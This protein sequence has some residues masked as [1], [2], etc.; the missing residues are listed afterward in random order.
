[1]CAATDSK[2]TNFHK[3]FMSTYYVP[4]T[5]LGT[6]DTVINKTF[7]VPDHMCSHSSEIH[8]SMLFSNNSMFLKIHSIMFFPKTDA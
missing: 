1:M 6:E 7:R 3:Y 5:V 4:G 2:F 8:S